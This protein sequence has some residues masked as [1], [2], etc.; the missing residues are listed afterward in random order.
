MKLLYVILLSV[1][2]T[3]P[4]IAH[5]SIRFFDESKPTTLRGALTKVDWANPHVN[6]TME[7]KDANGVATTWL[8]G[9]AAPN[10]LF[11]EGIRPEM[12]EVMK[13]S[14]VVIWP[15]RDGSRL[16]A[17]RTLTITGGRTLDVHDRWGDA[18]FAK[19]AR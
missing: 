5:H 13:T 6:I 9:L 16:G 7:V 14:S 12:F 3:A 11:R 8:I 2:V 17:G 1:A 19:V 4:L 15:A 10:A 18:D